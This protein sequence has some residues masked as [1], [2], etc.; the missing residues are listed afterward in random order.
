MKGM[1]EGVDAVF[2]YL[3]SQLRRL[4]PP[5]RRP[6]SSSSSSSLPRSL[7]KYFHRL[8]IFEPEERYE[9]IRAVRDGTNRIISNRVDYEAFREQHID[10][11]HT[12]SEEE[13]YDE[14]DDDEEGDEEQQQ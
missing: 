3:N 8:M 4:P 12:L 5:P 13:Y 7:N 14:W 11:D 6:P 10:H 9:F 1:N 2:N